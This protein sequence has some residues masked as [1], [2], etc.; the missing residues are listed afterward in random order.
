MGCIAAHQRN[1]FYLLCKIADN[2]FIDCQKRMNH[3]PQ[4][5]EEKRGYFFQSVAC[6]KTLETRS[7]LRFLRS[8]FCKWPVTNV[9]LL[10]LKIVA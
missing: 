7:L 3:V 8:I 6:L 4:L 2:D 10:T 1:V 9:T 5:K